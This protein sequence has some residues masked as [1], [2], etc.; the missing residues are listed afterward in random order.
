[1]KLTAVRRSRLLSMQA[2]ATKAGVSIRTINN[3][4]M[5]YIRPHL[6]TIQKLCDALNVDPMDVD[7]FRDAIQGKELAPITA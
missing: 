3:I 7:E 5:G 4:E 6:S 2:L 1:M